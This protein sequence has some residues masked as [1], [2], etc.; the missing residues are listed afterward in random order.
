MRVFLY[1]CC[2]IL[3]VLLS[4]VSVPLSTYAQI[5][6]SRVEVKKGN[7]FPIVSEGK[8]PDIYY[9]A[10]DNVLINKVSHIF[11]E[12]VN[13]V[14]G[15][16]PKVK[17]L[18]DQLNERMILVGTLGQ[19]RLI[20]QL[21]LDKRIDAR[22][23][24]GKWESFIIQTVEKPFKGVKEALVILGS[25]RRG[26]AYGVFT[27][28]KA[29]GVSP[30]Y[31]WADVPVAKS[32]QLYLKKCKY[33]AESPKV[34]YR[35]IFLNDERPCLVRW[36]YDKYGGLNHQ[37]YASIYELILRNKGN[38][39]W[40]AMYYSS[41]NGMITP[42]FAADDP[43]NASL[44][45][46]YGIVISTSHHEPMMRAHH[47]WYRLGRDGTTW[48]YQNNKQELQEFWR[49]GI[50]RMG[51]HES[52]VT[53]GMRGDGDT[54]LPG[55][56]LSMLENI[57]ADQRKIIEEVTGKQ[58]EKTPQVWTAYKDVQRYFDEGIQ[59]PEDITIMFTDD[60]WGNI[61]CVPKKELLNR[62][63]G[64]G[65][66][67]HFDYVGSPVSYK[68]TNVTQI[69]RTWEQLTLAYQWG[70]RDIWIVNI[71]DIKPH[72]FPCSFYFDLAWDPEAFTPD[73][74]SD[75]YLT[76]SKEQF[77]EK[78]AEG[79]AELLSKYTKFNARRTA[80]MLSPYTYSVEN[81]REA[82]RVEKEYQDLCDKA[83]AIYYQLDNA[84]KDAYSELILFPVESNSNLLSMYVA[85]AK[86]K[87][88]ATIGCANAANDYAEKTRYY[89]DGDKDIHTF[90][91]DLNKGKWK[92]IYDQ[93][94]IGHPDWCP[95][96]L[97]N[98][99]PVTYVHSTGKKAD[100]GIRPEYG[101]IYFFGGMCLDGIEWHHHNK[102]PKFDPINNQTYY[103][104]LYNKGDDPVRYTLEP[105]QE[106]IK[107]SRREGVTTTFDRVDISIDW[108][109]APKEET[110][111]YIHVAGAG[112]TFKV[113]VPI[114]NDI[115]K[116]SYQGFVENNG[117]VSIEAVHYG[118]LQNKGDIQW[119]HIPNLGR[120]LSA[121]TVRPSN[122]DPQKLNAETPYLE[123]QFAIIDSSKVTLDVYLSPT[124]NF[125]RNEGLKFAVSIDNGEPQI[126]NMHRD[127]G[128]WSI[129]V[130]NHIAI[131]SLKC[132]HLSKGNHTMK[133]WM[134]DPGV[135]FQKYVFDVRR[136]DDPGIKYSRYLFDSPINNPG[137][138]RD[139][140]LGPEESLFL[141]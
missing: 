75:Y 92:Y 30:W 139:S 45:D 42:A 116:S 106:W 108:E 63:G 57:V 124:Y 16:Q 52:I 89:F 66:Y 88:Y 130:G 4:I 133:V 84:Y 140:Y 22:K 47:E 60:N 39:L 91:R 122:A 98:M 64:F 111:G 121:M 10:G 6:V 131:E 23:I 17:T 135:V 85:A 99:P 12:D 11:A 117:V 14:T 102:M 119:K 67:Y 72:E 109:K 78:H 96:A 71:G 50:E 104:E 101:D 132:G 110:E 105:L 73:N 118:R 74:L 9:D 24:E 2:R 134:I 28:S 35:G 113:T 5:E 62:K 21:V 25:D 79:I 53:M 94:H 81:Y 137:S 95:P 48:D 7:Y 44:A 136:V 65:M 90:M 26:T 125:K 41:G 114:R 56:S 126:V 58:A 129:R 20:D 87:F 86:N 31:W 49:Y 43:E 107:V 55:G 77:G 19:N 82:D 38:L 8:C 97:D 27:I 93:V 138:L 100:L 34:K 54:Y 33:L 69:E 59:L 29:M 103:L 37:F 120:T 83:K 51:N 32:S 115:Q 15:I 76:W 13:R 68:W 112:Q 46:D 127:R 18:S 80:E 123:Y 128:K 36:A 3:L 141:K 40:P 61:Q 1:R 70:I